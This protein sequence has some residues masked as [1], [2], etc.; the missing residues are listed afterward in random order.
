[1]ESFRSFFPKSSPSLYGK[2]HQWGGIAPA[3]RAQIMLVQIR[4]VVGSSRVG[5]RAAATIKVNVRSSVKSYILY[6]QQDKTGLFITKNTLAKIY[7]TIHFCYCI[8]KLVFI[9]QNR[10]MFRAKI[11]SEFAIAKQRKILT[12]ETVQIGIS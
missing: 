9:F 4:R 2:Q 5:G 10:G 11:K 6:H 3:S 7:K 8:T 1:M 12:E